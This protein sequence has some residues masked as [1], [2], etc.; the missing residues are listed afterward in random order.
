MGFVEKRLAVLIGDP[1]KAAHAEK[2]KYSFSGLWSA[3]VDEQY[4]FIYRICKDCR[5]SGDELRRPIDCC[6]AGATDA[7]T[8]NILCIVDYH[9]GVDIPQDF[10]M[11]S[12]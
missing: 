4:R 6:Y 5:A 11:P 1:Y 7:E 3:H 12:P 2:L 8:V 10:T 9:P